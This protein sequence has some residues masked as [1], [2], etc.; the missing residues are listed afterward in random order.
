[1]NQKSY[2]TW[3][4]DKKYTLAKLALCHEGYKLTDRNHQEK[5][6]TIIEKLKM[7]PEFAELEIQPMAL[8]NQFSRMQKDVLKAAGISMEG[9]NLSGLSEE[10]SELVTLLC[11]MAKE[12]HDKK[13]VGKEKKKKQ[14]EKETAMNMTEKLALAQQGCSGGIKQEV[15]DEKDEGHSSKHSSGRKRG[16]SFMDDF[17]ANVIS[18]LDEDHEDPEFKQQKLNLEQQRLDLEKQKLQLQDKELFQ[19]HLE[20]EEAKKARIQTG[21]QMKQQ[22][23]QMMELLKL[24]VTRSST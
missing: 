11:N 10:P 15:T 5:W 2:F 23:E 16:R 20:L 19:R 17:N 21:E 13:I 14:K 12:V 4:E 18:L 7:K 1:M 24:L 9:A 3:T 8:K 22:G 6:E